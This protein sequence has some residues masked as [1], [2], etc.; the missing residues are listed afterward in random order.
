MQ[1]RQF[2]QLC[3]AAAAA[4][5]APAGSANARPPRYSRAPQVGAGGAPLR[6]SRVP[7]H[8]NQIIH[9]T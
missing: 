4:A 2:I 9:K 6:A 7:A 5:G 1:R 8:T 3:A